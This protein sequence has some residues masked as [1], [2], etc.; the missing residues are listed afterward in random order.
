MVMK[1]AKIGQLKARLNSY[2][3]EVRNGGTVTVYDRNVPIARIVPIWDEPDD[4]VVI[5]SS[6]PPS[7]LK[8]FKGVRPRKKIEIDSL[9]SE[10]RGNR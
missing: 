8:K 2:L 1:A 10:S 9:L 5:E 3:S 4:L 6:A 7:D